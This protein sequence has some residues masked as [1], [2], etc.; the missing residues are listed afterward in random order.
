MS[1]LESFYEPIQTPLNEMQASF[2]QTLKQFSLY[3]ALSEI[4]DFSTQSPGKWI[5][6][7]LCLYSFHLTSNNTTLSPNSKDALFKACYAIE[8]IQLASLIHDDIIDEAEL[9]RNKPCVYKEFGTH[10]GIIGGVFI[11][12]IALQLM[13]SIQDISLIESL[14]QAVSSLC[15]GEFEQM[16][17][18]FDY[19]LSQETYEHIIYLKT[20]ALFES[21][22]FIGA[23]LAGGS[24][25]Q[26]TSLSQFGKSFGMLFQLVDDYKDLFSSK[27]TL[28]KL[29][30]QD[31]I[32]GDISKP[33]L[34]LYNLL[35][36]K[37]WQQFLE[38]AKNQNLDAC[39]DCISPSIHQRVKEHM[40]ED[41]YRHSQD[42]KNSLNK[43]TE[44]PYQ[45][46]LLD[47]IERFSHLS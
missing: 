25:E 22:C 32:T 18:R 7:S 13:S 24:Q 4:L 17:R 19:N 21:S 6:A 42:I 38:H 35:D 44:S 8:A 28:Q 40:L 30:I 33:I 12:S 1:L 29:P 20:A 10:S 39:L 2:P 45:K 34:L 9:R 31:L 47:F 5:R 27:N 3:P 23:K 11:Y 36:T 43:Q 26:C 37:C 41:I 14:S 46:K 16:T 15:Q